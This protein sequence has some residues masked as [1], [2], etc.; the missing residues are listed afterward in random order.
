MALENPRTTTVFLRDNDPDSKI[1]VTL[2]LK[3]GKN[4]FFKQSD[5]LLEQTK[6]N[7]KNL[8][9]TVKGERVGNPEFGSNIFNLLFENFTTDFA[10]RLEDEIRLSVANWL[11]H[12]LLN[13]VIID[14]RQSDNAVN[15]TVQY[16]LVTDPNSLESLQ[17]NLMRSGD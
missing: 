3:V 1:G 12:V 9:L 16:A 10:K 7:L 6:S 2:P 15:I 14:A 8:L 11:P 13:G 5:T 17:L 4:G